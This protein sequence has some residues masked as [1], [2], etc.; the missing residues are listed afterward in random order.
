MK[1]FWNYGGNEGGE[2][3]VSKN[4]LNGQKLV[5]P[6]SNALMDKKSVTIFPH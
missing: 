2:M 6:R 5:F 1:E 4:V 3:P